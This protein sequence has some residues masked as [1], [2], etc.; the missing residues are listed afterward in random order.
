MVHNLIPYKLKVQL[1]T[2]KLQY[3]F[4]FQYS[5]A[6]KMDNHNNFSYICEVLKLFK[7]CPF[8]STPSW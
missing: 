5:S 6:N 1:K 3:V 4:T 7:M 2:Y 8:A